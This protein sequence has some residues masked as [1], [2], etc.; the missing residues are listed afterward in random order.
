MH[1]H[2][3]EAAFRERQKT[4]N[5]VFLVSTD[6]LSENGPKIELPVDELI[7]FGPMTPS[8]LLSKNFEEAIIHYRRW[9]GLTIKSMDILEKKE[10]IEYAW[11]WPSKKTVEW[12]PTKATVQTLLFKKYIID[13]LIKHHNCIS[14]WIP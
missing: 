3:V 7:T 6:L 12:I 2:D 4:I 8:A 14:T 11:P 9:R 10:K 5:V 13:L 1:T